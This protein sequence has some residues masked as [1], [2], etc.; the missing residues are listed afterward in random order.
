MFV[1]INNDNYRIPTNIEEYGNGSGAAMKAGDAVKL[2]SDGDVELVGGATNTAKVFGIVAKDATATG[3]VSV[4]RVTPT[5]LFRTKATAATNLASA[6]PGWKVAIDTTDHGAVVVGAS[7]ITEDGTTH[8]PYIGAV[9]VET[10]T[11]V[12]NVLVRFGTEQ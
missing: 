6:K 7:A 10:P 12:N 3:K 4:M 9:I 5:M 8:V 2:A 11:D 1:L